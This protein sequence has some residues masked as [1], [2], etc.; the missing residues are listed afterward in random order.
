MHRL[1][2]DHLEE[3]LSPAGFS[4]T[5]P[6]RKHLESCEE[7]RTEIGEMREHAAL[8]AGL[9]AEDA[10]AERAEELAMRPGFYARVWERIEAQ[11]PVSIWE[12]FALSAF[13]RGLAAASLAVMMSMGAYL[14]NAE[15]TA[16]PQTTASHEVVRQTYPMLPA[17]D[18]PDE[19]FAVPARGIQPTADATRGAVLMSLVSYH[20]Q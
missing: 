3:L 15:V 14:V 20:G 6:A 8:L 4:A 19:V 11:R 17:A 2:E 5:H 13:G 9:R 16:N 1:I 10:E 12:S 18:F 7:C